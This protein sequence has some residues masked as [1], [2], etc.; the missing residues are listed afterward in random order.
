MQTSDIIAFEP[1]L[2]QN[3]I[4]TSY[5]ASDSWDT[6]AVPYVLNL[7]NR[8]SE[9]LKLAQRHYRLGCLAAWLGH[10]TLIVI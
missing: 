6:R 8:Y 5:A 2:A 7:R 1:F 3:V 10:W 9:L 4:K